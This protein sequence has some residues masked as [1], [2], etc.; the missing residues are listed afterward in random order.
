MKPFS[1]KSVQ[2]YGNEE[3]LSGNIRYA[4]SLGLPEIVPMFFSHDGTWVIVGSGPS[5]PDFLDDIRKEREQGRP[6]VALN[7]AHD[8]LCEH[9][10][11]P[12]IFIT[13]DPRPMPQNLKY[14]N[15]KTFYLIGSRCSGET[16]DLLKDRKVLMWHAW[17][18][19]YENALL[20]GKFVIT[21]GT[22]SGLRA[23]SIGYVMGFRKFVGYGMD[24]CFNGNI[25]RCD[26]IIGEKMPKII[27]I[28]VGGKTFYTNYA[29]AAQA[30][31]FQNLYA[32][33]PDISIEMKG[34]GILAAIIEERRKLGLRC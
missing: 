18:E 27:D 7:G 21:G 15:N 22:T 23:F 6:I 29:M 28:V 19:P 9:G 11:V 34:P 13:I 26:G 5:L 17:G 16:L 1:V 12:D 2:Q 3:E 8:Y 14:A 32:A 25:K 30:N 24:S 20:M 33:L 31:E 10:I 4:L